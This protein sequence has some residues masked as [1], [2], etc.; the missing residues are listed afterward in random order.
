MT[1]LACYIYISS[2]EYEKFV[3]FGFGSLLTDLSNAGVT[4]IIT[5]IMASFHSVVLVPGPCYHTCWLAC[6]SEWNGAIAN[7]ISYTSAFPAV[8]SD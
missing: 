4:D 6:T 7:N 8:K 2:R 5:V 3:I 1:L